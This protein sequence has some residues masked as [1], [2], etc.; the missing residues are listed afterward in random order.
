[1]SSIIESKVFCTFIEKD[2]FNIDEELVFNV[3]DVEQ[4]EYTN[5]VLFDAG[6][7]VSER[8]YT[9]NWSFPASCWCRV[10]SEQYNF[11]HKSKK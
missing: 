6:E 11:N 10:L 1:M 8:L 3:N 2:A 7:L 4:P 9:W 5:N